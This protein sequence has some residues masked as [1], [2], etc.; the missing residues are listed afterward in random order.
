MMID[1]EVDPDELQFMCEDTTD[2]RF[3]LNKAFNYYSCHLQ[4]EHYSNEEYVIIN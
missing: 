3:I 1:Q 2:Y 4:V